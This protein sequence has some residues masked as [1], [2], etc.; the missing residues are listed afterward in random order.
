MSTL[1]WAVTGTVSGL[2]NN[3][4]GNSIAA[5]L[6][7]ASQGAS[8]PTAASTGLSATSGLF[9]HDTSANLLKL[10]DQADTAWMAY[11]AVDETNKQVISHHGGCRLSFVSSTSLKLAPYGIP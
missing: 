4:Q 1:Q 11:A 7:T 8:A 6:A 3:Q 5:A 10:R 2:Q 9:W